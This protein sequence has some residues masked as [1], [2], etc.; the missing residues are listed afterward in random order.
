MGPLGEGRWLPQEPLWAVE[1]TKDK[2]EV[3]S[4]QDH[5]LYKSYS[6]GCTPDRGGEIAILLIPE[7]LLININ[8][9]NYEMTL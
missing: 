2:T 4:S 6:E 8:F 1:M 3:R 9:S 7:S 5:S